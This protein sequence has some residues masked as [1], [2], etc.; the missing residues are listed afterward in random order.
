MLDINDMTL[1]Q[2]CEAHPVWLDTKRGTYGYQSYGDSANLAGRHFATRE[3]AE[4]QREREWERRQA[5]KR[6][7]AAAEAGSSDPIRECEKWDMA[8]GWAQIS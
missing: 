1:E 4:R 5:Q 2:F 7:V 8:H 6:I 3:A